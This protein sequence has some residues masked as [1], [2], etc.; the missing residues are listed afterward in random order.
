VGIDNIQSLLLEKPCCVRAG[1]IL[2]GKEEKQSSRQTTGDTNQSASRTLNRWGSNCFSRSW[3]YPSSRDA[4]AFVHWLVLRRPAGPRI[5]TRLYFDPLTSRR[6]QGQGFPLRPPLLGVRVHTSGSQHYR[7]FAVPPSRPCFAP[8]L[9]NVFLLSTSFP[10]T[11]TLLGSYTHILHG[12]G[13]AV[14]YLL[15]KR[16]SRER[17]LSFTDLLGTITTLTSSTWA[18][19]DLRQAAKR[20][21][22]ER[23]GAGEQLFP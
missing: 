19:Q 22:L 20:A 13:C 23:P 9:G 5:G 6:V 18:T 2:P 16:V 21:R 10:G 4:I 7:N 15:R 8:T 17:Y 3:E 11:S 14:K 1:K 12:Y